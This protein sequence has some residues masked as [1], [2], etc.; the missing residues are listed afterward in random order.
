LP[1]INNKIKEAKKIAA[2]YGYL[3]YIIE[4][5]LE[6]LSIDETIKL[7]E[8]N[9]KPLSLWIRT[10]TLKITPYELSKRLK[11][12]GFILK[13]NELI[14][15]AFEIEKQAFNLGSLHEYLQGY[16]YI[17]NIASIF[18]AHILNPKPNEF[19]IDMCAA[20]GGKSTHL[21][22]L[23]ENK[24]TLI[25][26]ERNRKRIPALEANICRMGIYNS[27][28]LNFDAKNLESLDFKADKILLD[29]PCTGEGLIRQDPSRKKSKSIHDI[30]KMAEI[31]KELLFSGLNSLKE[32]GILLYSTC[33]I[34]PE[35]NEFV[36]NEVLD[37]KSNIEIIQIEKNYGLPG[38]SKV[39]G[40]SLRSELKYS[41]RFFPHIH[42]SIGFFICLMKKIS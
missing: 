30:Q 3:P 32:N 40:K 12:K 21:A 2:D 13:K 37:K 27:I 42:D 26:I 14:P 24:G 4:R 11:E 23:M 9:E 22:Q 1:P 15:Y 5:Y 39:F 19:V 34:A 16:Y 7:L 10:N 33:S 8:A 17:Q 25:L 36:I 38:Y 29:A 28:I 6:F 31:Q 35:E 18:P 41:Q 20:P